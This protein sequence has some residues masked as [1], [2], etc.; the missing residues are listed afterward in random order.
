MDILCF[1][2]FFSMLILAISSVMQLPSSALRP[3]VF[4]F[5]LE[6]GFSA[7][8]KC[9]SPL[10]IVVSRQA[11]LYFVVSCRPRRSWSTRR[12]LKFTGSSCEPASPGLPGPFGYIL[13]SGAT[14]VLSEKLL[15]TVRLFL[16]LL[17]PLHLSVAELALLLRS[18]RDL[19]PLSRS[20]ALVN[21]VSSSSFPDLPR[22]LLSKHCQICVRYSGNCG[23][24]ARNLRLIVVD[25]VH[26]VDVPKMSLSSPRGEVYTKFR[27]SLL[28]ARC[29]S[30]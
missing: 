22:A 14:F 10:F 19:A 3:S 21:L 5:S 12:M 23:V 16:C 27:N 6:R 18:R 29:G 11:L 2:F 25:F 1:A 9:Y 17:L 20:R 4:T 13:C 26:S 15:L 30:L 8:P 24:F 7:T 28:K